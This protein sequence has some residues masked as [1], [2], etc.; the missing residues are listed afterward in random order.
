LFIKRRAASIDTARPI[1]NVFLEYELRCKPGVPFCLIMS[2]LE[3][4]SECGG[5]GQ[6]RSLHFHALDNRHYRDGK[7]SITRVLRLI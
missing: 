2:T 6:R 4:L 7:C 3:I 1:A 5:G